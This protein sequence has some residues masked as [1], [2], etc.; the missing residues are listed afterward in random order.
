MSG[1]DQDQYDPATDESLDSKQKHQLE[2]IEF[3]LVRELPSGEKLTGIYG[4]NVAKVREVVKLPKINK[5]AASAEGIEGLFELRKIPIPAINLCQILGDEHH[6]VQPEHQIIVTEFSGRRA[7]FIVHSTHR[8]RR[9]PWSKVLPPSADAKSCISG[10]VLLDETQFL[11]ILDLEKIVEDIE[12]PGG[13]QEA[14]PA[15]SASAQQVASNGQAL[16]VEDSAVIRNKLSHMLTEWGFEVTIATDGME[17]LEYLQTIRDTK[18]LKLI[19]TDLEMP[20]MD[21]YTLIEHIQKQSQIAE[22]PVIIHSSL[23]EGVVEKSNHKI[24]YF[25]YVEKNDHEK[26]HA[27][28]QQALDL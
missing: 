22:I 28:V 24:N 16:L 14:V 4:I 8:I 26:L 13:L 1:M 11:L 2:L 20:R 17:A 25:A 10:M 15:L 7:G 12:N 27:V 21:G 6:T 3:S 23:N 18:S 9:I 19:V 5:L